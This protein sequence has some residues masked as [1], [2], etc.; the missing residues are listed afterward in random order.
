M[1]RAHNSHW[2]TVEDLPPRI[3]MTAVPLGIGETTI[4]GALQLRITGTSG[5]DQ[6]TVK[7]TRT[8]LLVGNTGG[9]TRTITDPV[10]TLWINGGAGN[11]SIALDASVTLNA[12]V[13]GGGANDNIVAGSGNNM[14][15]GG[16]GKNVLQSRTGND[17]LVTLGSTGDTLIGG[18]GH[19]SF[20]TDNTSAEKIQNLTA[21]ET[22]AGAVHRISSFYN[23][24]AISVPGAAANSAKTKG[25]FT[26]GTVKE[27]TVDSGVSYTKKATNPIF[28]DTGPSENDIFQGDLSDCYYLSVLSSIAKIDPTRIQQSILDMSDGTAIV[29]LFK[30]GKPIYVREDEMLPA[31]T[32][33]SL[34]YAGLGTENSS[35]AALMEKA[36]AYV[37]TSK[38][39]YPSLNVGWMDEAYQALGVNKSV[40][41]YTFASAAALMNVIKQALSAGQSVTCATNSAPPGT[42]LIASHAYTVDSVALD[43]TGNVKSVTLRNPWGC[44]ADGTGNGYIT[45]SPVTAF[46]ALAGVTCAS[47]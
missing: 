23:G 45:L 7:Q 13:I 20:W 6:I 44:N 2:V 46:K 38:A 10:K 37:R 29:Q 12:T 8:G 47:V 33:G 32:D 18:S 21:A 28:A 14:L 34:Y 25:V 17:T 41:T 27:P 15:Y 39:S 1:H 19:D 3:L 5:N 16:S 35:W 11:N 36:F 26:T 31:S 4:D 43:S 42:A 24:S 9:W 22:A 30:N 40:S